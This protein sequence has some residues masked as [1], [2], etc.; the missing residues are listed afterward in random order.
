MTQ[1]ED[2]SAHLQRECHDGGDEGQQ[3]VAGGPVV[4]A[5]WGC[6][7]GVNAHV[8]RKA[9]FTALFWDG[10]GVSVRQSS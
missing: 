3:G 4:V 9:T 7:G 5:A 10:H 2:K 8:R 1:R 6:R